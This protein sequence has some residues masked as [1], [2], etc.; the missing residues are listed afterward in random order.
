VK[1]HGIQ[2]ILIREKGCA[3]RCNVDAIPQLHL[4]EFAGCCKGQFIN[5]DHIAR[6][7]P[8]RYFVSEKAQNVLLGDLYSGVNLKG[9][10]VTQPAALTIVLV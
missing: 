7:P 8:L 4:L 3:W 6:K 2:S 1:D 9:M 10:V 5:E